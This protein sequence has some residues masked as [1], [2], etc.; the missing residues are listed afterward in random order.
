M[1]KKRKELQAQQQAME[2]KIAQGYQNEQE[3]LIQEEKEA[4]R[5]EM[6][7]RLRA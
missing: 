2:A 6:L 5:Q 4:K 3:K 1:E 7:S